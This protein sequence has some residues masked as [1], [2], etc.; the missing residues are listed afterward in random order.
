MNMI[1]LFK[2]HNAEIQAIEI[3]DFGTVYRSVGV[4]KL[5]AIRLEMIERGHKTPISCHREFESS[6]AFMIVWNK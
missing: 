5:D 6:E 1:E 4:T 3:K 2:K